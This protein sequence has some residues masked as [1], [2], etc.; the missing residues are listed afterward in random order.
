VL[1]SLPVGQLSAG[2]LVALIVLLILTGRLVTRQQLRDTQ[3]NCDQ[4]RSAAENW[5]KA[6]YE[7]GMAVTKLTAAV[8]ASDHAL[9]EIQRG[10][11][12]RERPR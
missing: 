9:S 6:H 10:L 7:V 1:D 3:A 5:Q 4:W 12:E 11:A 8:E 2:A